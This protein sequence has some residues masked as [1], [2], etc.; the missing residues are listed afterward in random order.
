MIANLGE[1]VLVPSGGLI[2]RGEVVRKYPEMSRRFL[3]AL[4]LALQHI[5]KT[6]PTRSRPASKEVSRGSRIS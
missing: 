3:R 1:P 2:A 4:M 5:R 6:K